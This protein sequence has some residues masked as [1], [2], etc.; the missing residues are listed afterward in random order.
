MDGIGDENE[1][2]V[3]EV[4]KLVLDL[5]YIVGNYSYDY[6]IYNCVEEFGFISGVDCN[7]TGNY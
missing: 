4:L 3:L 2:C 5:G 6:M 7:V 1:D